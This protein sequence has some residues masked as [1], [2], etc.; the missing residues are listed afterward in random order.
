MVVVM[1]GLLIGWEDC[2]VYEMT[3]FISF[4]V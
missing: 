1:F 2:L 4:I 3:S